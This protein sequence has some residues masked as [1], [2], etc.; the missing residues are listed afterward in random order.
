V[1]DNVVFIDSGN[2]LVSYNSSL[3]AS[4]FDPETKLELG[5]ILAAVNLTC[6]YIQT[7]AIDP[8]G[9]LEFACLWFL[10]DDND[11]SSMFPIQIVYSG[12]APFY[13]NTTVTAA[14]MDDAIVNA[15]DPPQVDSLISSLTTDLNM[16]NPFSWTTSISAEKL[17]GSS[18]STN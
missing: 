2:I 3:N 13:T 1:P 8:L 15:F 11:D 17:F 5:Q 14:D 9:A 6:A 12:T 7:Q 10:T 18:N 4:Q 16:T